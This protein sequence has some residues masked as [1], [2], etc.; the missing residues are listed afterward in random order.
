LLLQH[1]GMVKNY[2]SSAPSNSKIDY[3]KKA[4]KAAIDE[5][6]RSTEVRIGDL[7]AKVFQLLEQLQQR[8][9]AIEGVTYLSQSLS[10]IERA[11][12]FNWRA[13]VY[14]LLRKFDEAAYEELKT[15]ED[16]SKPTRPPSSPKGKQLGK[17]DFNVAAPEFVPGVYWSG[18]LIGITPK[19]DFGP[20]VMYSFHM[21]PPEVVATPPPK[22]STAGNL[23]TDSSEKAPQE[24]NSPSHRLCLD[25]VVSNGLQLPAEPVPS[26]GSQ[27]HAAGTCKPCA[28]LHT[29]G[30]ANGAECPFCHL[31][32]AEE[33]K[34]RKQ[35]R[36]K[37]LTARAS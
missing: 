12:I 22:A 17:P 8:E 13:Y 21:P 2:N 20:G 28:F 18:R 36:R 30:C 24:G 26:L 5:L 1:L 14:T 19:A 3:S 4:Y 7:D 32:D 34:R 25:E 15:A 9:R 27:G 29:K 35:Q 37:D 11:R 16:A 6:V 10:G 33:K 23:D 31:C